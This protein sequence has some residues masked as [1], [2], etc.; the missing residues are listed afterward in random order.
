MLDVAGRMSSWDDLH[1]SGA[2]EFVSD[3][4]LILQQVIVTLCQDLSI[5][6]LLHKAL[7]VLGKI[8]HIQQVQDLEGKKENFMAMLAS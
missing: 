2:M 5:D 4:E 6:G 8:H 1:Y 7:A 3:M